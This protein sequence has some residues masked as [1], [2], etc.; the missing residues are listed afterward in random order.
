MRLN[1]IS[2]SGFRGFASPVHLDLNSD[3]VIVVAENGRGKTSL[4][5]AILWALTGGVPR[6]A[7]SDSD[8]LS[9]FSLNGTMT[10][11][12]SLASAGERSL[13]VTRSFDGA[14]SQ[15][16]VEI[17]GQPAVT[18][19]EAEIAV[20]R[21]LWPSSLSSASPTT[22][23]STVLSNSVYLQQDLVKKFIED[24]ADHDRYE[25]M[26][27]LLGAGRLSDLQLALDQ[28]KQSYANVTTRAEGATAAVRVRRDTLKEELDAIQ[29]IPQDIASKLEDVW[30]AVALN[31]T[32]LLPE[33]SAPPKLPDRAWV[34]GLLRQL[35]LQIG[36]LS[37][38]I[39]GTR[40][41]ESLL[42][43]PVSPTIGGPSEAELT[44]LGRS[45]DIARTSLQSLRTTELTLQA[46][47]QAQSTRERRLRELAGLALEFLD[48]DCPVCGQVHDKARTLARLRESMDHDAPRE[49][50]ALGQV[51]EQIEVTESEL[52]SLSARLEALEETAEAARREGSTRRSRESA[53]ADQL[54]ALQLSINPT[55]PDVRA[56]V[57]KA[58][59]SF[60][61]RLGELYLLL[62]QTEELSLFSAQT[63]QA[64]AAERLRKDLLSIE[65]EL[66]VLEEK[67]DRRGRTLELAN[68]VA[69]NL[70]KVSDQ[71]VEQQ[72]ERLS[73]ILQRIISAVDAHPV[74]RHAQLVSARSGRKGLLSTRFS[75]RSGNL[76]FDNPLGVLSSSQAN[77]FAI[78][79]FLSLNLGIRPPIET[80]ILDDPLQS[81]DDVH[82]LGVVDVLRRVADKRQIVVG[83]HD[84]AFGRLL[85]RKLR[86]ISETSNR[87]AA[88]ITFTDWTEQG[89]EV[90]VESVD[91]EPNALK[92][93][94]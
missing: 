29:R 71:F 1:G 7:K 86:P 53:A 94:V 82:L 21:N 77:A 37:Q 6:I 57:Q 56:Q 31:A 58:G 90:R 8:L 19:A 89:P 16:R 79:V 48:G 92:V 22:S 27:E 17:D 80:A 44:L 51:Q 26:A 11:S 12:L 84:P 76:T 3:A 39:E 40:A 63:E 59:N 93:A 14:K 73:P 47:R 36:I 28:A 81:L 10:V 55:K 46:E 43:L 41:V 38:K 34:D 67:A 33:A 69:P 30:K 25:V 15:V 66:K 62:R 4:F 88:V 5:D 78:A 20:A 83:T 87:S 65:E 50:Q 2:I 24:G 23:L 72:L 85:V 9:K 42:D 52:R 75:D 64:A 68:R 70:R 18:G 61:V 13:S 54:R 32:R 91:V 49:S 35:Q 60:R 74:F 45:L